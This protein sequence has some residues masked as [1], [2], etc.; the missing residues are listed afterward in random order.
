MT[1]GICVGM[2]SAMLNV[3]IYSFAS[4]IWPEDVESQ[5]S[6]L[7]AMSGIG[8]ILGPIMGSIVYTF[9]GFKL[10]FFIFGA[11]LIPVTF[12]AY[13]YLARKQREQTAFTAVDS[14]DFQKAD[15]VGI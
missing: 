15:A 3:S 9:A 6:K 8:L 13:Y 2:A 14:D 12:A 5:I 7:E 4:L 11:C 10:S 1:C